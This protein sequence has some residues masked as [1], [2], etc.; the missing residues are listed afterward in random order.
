MTESEDLDQLAAL[1]SVDPPSGAAL[2]AAREVLWSAVADEMLAGLTGGAGW[3]E[4]RV[5][6]RPATRPRPRQ[7]RPAHRREGSD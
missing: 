6:R 7:A 1:G 5:A 2:A 3:P 4:P